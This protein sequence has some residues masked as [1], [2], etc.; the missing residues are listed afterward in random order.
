MTAQ[1]LAIAGSVAMLAMGTAIDAGAEDGNRDSALEAAAVSRVASS[2]EAAGRTGVAIDL[3]R[4]SDVGA[5]MAE[6]VP[7]WLRAQAA[8]EAYRISFESIRLAR[9]GAARNAAA[10]K[11]IAAY[12][13]VGRGA[14][15]LSL[16]LASGDVRLRKEKRDRRD[17]LFLGMLYTVAPRTNL[18]VEYRALAGGDL[19][20]QGASRAD[21]GLNDH[22]VLVRFQHRF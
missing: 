3:K 8:A 11:T 10:W 16:D 1:R 2:T 22:S 20:G 14:L 19:P 17:Q 21:S 12:A 18:A 7:P 13:G 4:S 5:A 6:T 15:R 9:L